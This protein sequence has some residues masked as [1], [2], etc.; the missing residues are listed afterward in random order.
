MTAFFA[1]WQFLTIFPTPKFLKIQTADLEKSADFFPLVGLML[2]FTVAALDIGLHFVFPSTLVSVLLVILLI[3]VSGGLHADGLADTADGFLSS[4]PRERI[5]EIMRDSRSGPMAVIVL[6]SVFT[7]KWAALTELTG[8]RFWQLVLLPLVS[9]WAIL[10]S[11]NLNSYSRLNGGLANI[12]IKRSSKPSL[13]ISG[14][15]I[16]VF[17]FASIGTAGIA[18]FAV[19]VGFTL[20]FSRYC[21]KKIGG[22]T[23]DTLGAVCELTEVI[24]L[25]T[26]VLTDRMQHL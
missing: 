13:V 16:A 3:T 12:F 25:L 17:S 24:V 23:G 21:R 1:A 20:L 14:G 2:G 18:I 26:A 19:S 7:V 10:F 6:I 22:F 4:R 15:L 8:P 11:M 9:R 5:L